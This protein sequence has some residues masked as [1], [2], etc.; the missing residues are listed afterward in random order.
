MDG[1]VRTYCVPLGK[2]VSWS[3]ETSVDSSGVTFGP[4]MIGRN[5]HSS[6]RVSNSFAA[7][8]RT[9]CCDRMRRRGSSSSAVAYDMIGRTWKLA[10]VSS[11]SAALWA[12]H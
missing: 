3:Y 12:R 5:V 6:S 7:G 8:S 2:E 11:I 9:I 1:V 10:W 4:P